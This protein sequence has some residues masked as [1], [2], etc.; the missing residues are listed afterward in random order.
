MTD[1]EDRLEAT[2]SQALAGAPNPSPEELRQMICGLNRMITGGRVTPEQ[3]EKLAKEIETRHAVS[4]GLASVVDDGSIVPWLDEAKKDIDPYYWKRYKQFLVANGFPPDV[5]SKLDLG[6][7]QILSR[8]G[9]PRKESAWDRRGMVV[10]HV[11]SGK[12]AN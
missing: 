12:T 4:I 7:E 1:D 3:C 9:N 11:Q 6:T 8:L 2:V 10:G 5:V